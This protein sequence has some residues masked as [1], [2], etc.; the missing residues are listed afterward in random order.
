MSGRCLRGR[1]VEADSIGILMLDEALLS[2]ERQPRFLDHRNDQIG[3]DLPLDP[4]RRKTVVDKF[5]QRDVVL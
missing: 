4:Q 2:A 3:R 5:Q 1:S